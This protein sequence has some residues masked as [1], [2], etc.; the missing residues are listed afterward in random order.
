[1]KG[2]PM[3][4]GTE[5]RTK[6]EQQRAM[7]FHWLTQCLGSIPAEQELDATLSAV[8]AMV[9]HVAFGTTSPFEAVVRVQDIACQMINKLAARLPSSPKGDD[10]NAG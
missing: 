10:A 3:S 8:G 2:Q 4:D 1:M 6:A 7:S 5:D 9:G